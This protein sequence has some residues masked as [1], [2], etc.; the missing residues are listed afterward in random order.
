MEYKACWDLKFLSKHERAALLNQCLSVL[1]VIYARIFHS[2]GSISICYSWNHTPAS[3]SLMFSCTLSI[4]Y[5]TM[6]SLSCIIIFG[7]AALL[8]LLVIVI[9][10]KGSTENPCKWKYRSRDLKDLPSPFSLFKVG[11]LPGRWAASL[12]RPEKILWSKK[13]RATRNCTQILLLSLTPWPE[14]K[15]KQNKK[16]ARIE[17]SHSWASKY[18]CCI[19]SCSPSWSA[20]SHCPTS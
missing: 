2:N 20:A 11:H 7:P 6:S 19:A 18:D 17:V 8:A 9:V 16:Q 4:L 15:T 10:I 1:L 12:Q 5:T 3:F 13:C 14:N